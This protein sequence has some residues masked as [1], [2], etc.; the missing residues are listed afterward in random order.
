LRVLADVVGHVESVKTIDADEKYMLNVGL[1]GGLCD[2]NGS[3]RRKRC[4]QQGKQ[5]TDCH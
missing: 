3:K 5:T 2:R 1:R 4:Q